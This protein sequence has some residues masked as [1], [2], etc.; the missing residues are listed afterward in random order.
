MITDFP[1][2]FARFRKIWK[3]NQ[4]LALPPG[5]EAAEKPDLESPVFEAG[6]DQVH[7]AWLSVLKTAS[8]VS[9]IRQQ[10]GQIEA[11]Q[12]TPLMGFPDWITAEP[13]DLGAGK[14]SIAVFS[15]SK[16]GIRDLGA[17]EQRVN[18]WIDRLKGTMAG[19]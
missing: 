9:A 4:F 8:K 1:L 12:K 5:F 7:A 17:N 2:D 6:I 16:Y 18:S 11:V 10:G 13:I 19:Q 3:P 15:R 14:A